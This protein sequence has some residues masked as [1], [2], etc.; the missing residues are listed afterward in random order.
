MVYRV[1]S[2]IAWAIQRNPV[3]KNKNKTQNE[4]LERCLSCLAAL[5]EDLGLV[6]SSHVMAHNHP[7][8]QLQEIRLPLTSSVTRHKCVTCMYMWAK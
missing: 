3:S 1:S 2:R 7:Q 5:A 4:G 6:P 8:L